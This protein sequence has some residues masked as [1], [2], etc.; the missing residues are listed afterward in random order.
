MTKEYDE[1]KKDFDHGPNLLLILLRLFVVA[2]C[3]IAIVAAILGSLRVFYVFSTCF[4]F[5]AAFLSPI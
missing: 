2:G 1:N 4:R 5:I 3:F